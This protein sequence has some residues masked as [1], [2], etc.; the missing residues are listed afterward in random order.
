MDGEINSSKNFR[1]EIFY[2][3]STKNNFRKKN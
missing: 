2:D 3:K 1:N